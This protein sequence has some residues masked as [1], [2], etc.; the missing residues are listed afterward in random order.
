MEVVYE[1]KD[2]LSRTP[3]KLQAVHQKMVYV[4]LCHPISRQ[5]VTYQIRA[6]LQMIHLEP[7]TFPALLIYTESIRETTCGSAIIPHHLSLAEQ[8]TNMLNHCETHS[9]SWNKQRRRKEHLAKIGDD[10]PVIVMTC[11]DSFQNKSAKDG[12]LLSK[13]YRRETANHQTTSGSSFF[14]WLK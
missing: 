3:R 8:S 9:M 7:S 2:R 14:E 13:E 11:H 1:R 4:M 6:C 5:V 10:V 12:T